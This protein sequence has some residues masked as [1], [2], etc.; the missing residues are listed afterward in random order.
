MFAHNKGQPLG[1]SLPMLQ[2]GT[3]SSG[4]FDMHLYIKP[5]KSGDLKLKIL[6]TKQAKA[7][8]KLSLKVRGCLTAASPLQL[9]LLHV[10][11]TGCHPN[12][13]WV[14]DGCVLKDR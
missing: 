14:D 7:M 13:D 6:F 5:L 1:L 12:G 3:Q 9:H 11:L 8:E 10:D 2:Q 4:I